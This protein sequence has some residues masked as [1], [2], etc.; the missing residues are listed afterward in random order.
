[1]KRNRVAALY[2]VNLT[3]TFPIAEF[4]NH[5]K[6]FFAYFQRSNQHLFDVSVSIN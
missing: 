2:S 6:H 5:R 4:M 1:M 3:V